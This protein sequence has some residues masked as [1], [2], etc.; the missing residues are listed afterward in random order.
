MPETTIRTALL[1]TVATL[2]GACTSEQPE[3]GTT[4][5]APATVGRSP[6]AMPRRPAPEEASVHFVTPEDGAIVSSP[7]RVV[8]A[9]TGMDLVPAGKDAENSGH[10]HVLIDTD[11]PDLSLPIPA[12]EKHVHFGDGSATAELELPPGKHTLQLLFA[13]YLHIPHDAPVYSERITITVE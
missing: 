10:H 11:L 1:L 5:V 6:A 2:A 13:D 12:D 7:V 3:A 8:F 4:A 9:I